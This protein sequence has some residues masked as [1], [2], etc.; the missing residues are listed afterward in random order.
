MNQSSST[1]TLQLV[2]RL[3]L[4]TV[5]R[6]TVLSWKG[7]TRTVKSN[8]WP[9]TGHPQERHHIKHPR[10]LSELHKYGKSFKPALSWPEYG[11]LLLLPQVQASR[12]YSQ[13]PGLLSQGRTAAVTSHSTTIHLVTSQHLH[14]PS[15]GFLASSI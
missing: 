11:P 13:Q 12:F 6:T 1:H 4:S 3:V 10:T 9:C 15:Q 14:Q 7:P 2:L 8:S 5:Q